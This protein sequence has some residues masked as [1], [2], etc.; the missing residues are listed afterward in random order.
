M[1]VSAK[2]KDKARKEAAKQI[3]S[4]LRKAAPSLVQQS[5]DISNEINRAAILLYEK[6]YEGIEEA[7]ML[8]FE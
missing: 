5:I 1:T 7:W 8:F 2:S 4:V 3:L 6:W